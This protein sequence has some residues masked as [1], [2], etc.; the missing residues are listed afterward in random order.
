MDMIQ[1]CYDMYQS[2][3]KFIYEKDLI[4]EGKTSLRAALYPIFAVFAQSVQL[5]STISRLD[6]LE[7]PAIIE[8][9]NRS[10]DRLGARRARVFDLDRSDNCRSCERNSGIKEDLEDILAP[11]IEPRRPIS[12]HQ[13]LFIGQYLKTSYN[14]YEQYTAYLDYPKLLSQFTKVYVNDD[15][16]RIESRKNRTAENVGDPIWSSQSVFT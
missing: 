16:Y 8:L 14:R 11:R 7:K 13:F 15:G 9:V 6:G 2:I 3:T 4:Y 10:P 12:F 5:D 1:S